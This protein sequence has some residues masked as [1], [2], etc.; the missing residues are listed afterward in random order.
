MKVIRYRRENKVHSPNM[1]WMNY[2]LICLPMTDVKKYIRNT[3]FTDNT[4]LYQ[5]LE[6]KYNCCMHLHSNN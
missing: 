4:S 2:E 5:K 1:E 3:L 6:Q